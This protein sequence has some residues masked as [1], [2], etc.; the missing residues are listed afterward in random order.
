[1]NISTGIILSV[2]QEVLKGKGDF[3]SKT[4]TVYKAN[5]LVAD[6]VVG[7]QTFQRLGTINKNNGQ[8]ATANADKL[9]AEAKKHINV[10]YVWG[11]STPKGFDCSGYL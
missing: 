5:G 10:P 4:T 1:M 3:T 2:L 9:I 8:V 7:K 11:G 6:G